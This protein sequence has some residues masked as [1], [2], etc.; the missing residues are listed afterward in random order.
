MTAGAEPSTIG[1]QRIIRVFRYLQGLDQLRNPPKKCLSDHSW[2]LWLKNLPEHPTVLR[3][4]PVAFLSE[5][6]NVPSLTGKQ[7][8]TVG[9]DFILKVSRP[10]P[11]LAPEPPSQ[12]AKWLRSGWDEIDASIEVQPSCLLTRADGSTYE[13]RFEDEESRPLLLEDWRAKRK[14]WERDERPALDAWK[15]FERLYELHGQLEREGERI[16]LVLGDGILSW[17]VAGDEIRYPVILQRLQLHFNPS[18][19]QITLDES[20]YPVELN[21]ALLRTL[22][23][24]DGSLI[25]HLRNELQAKGF[26]PLDGD[27]TS[28]YFRQLVVQ[29]SPR[30]ELVERSHIKTPSSHPVIYRDPVIFLRARTHGF[31]NAIE[32]ILKDIPSRTEL[33]NSLLSIVG[34]GQIESSTGKDS[35]PLLLGEEAFDDTLFCKPAN[36]EQLQIARRLE[37]YGAVLTQG[38]PGTGK[39]YTIANLLGHLLAHGKTVLV[40]SHTSKALR[41]LRNQV[42][43]E[44]QPL[45]VSHLDSD[46][47]SRK[48]MERSVTAISE[49]LTSTNYEQLAHDAQI[50]S[51][52]RREVMA[53]IYDVRRRLLD[54]LTREYEDIQTGEGPYSPS[55]AARTV[56]DGIG[57]HDWIPGPVFM[58][59]AMPLTPEEIRELYLT[60]RTVSAEDER[61]LRGSLPNASDILDPDNFE[62]IVGQWLEL[63]DSQRTF[64]SIIWE[65]TKDGQDPDNLEAKLASITQSVQTVQHAP[66]W[67]LEAMDSG[68]KGGVH[69][70]VWED[71][72]NLILQTCETGARQEDE[73]IRL[74]PKL[75][76]GIELQEQIRNLCEIVDHLRH[77]KKLGWFTLLRHPHWRRLVRSAQIGGSR[78]SLDEHFDVLQNLAT[79]TETRRHLRKMYEH[80]MTSRGAPNISEDDEKPEKI[81]ERA[82]SAIHKACRWYADVWQ[83]QQRTLE[84]L[85]F[86]WLSFLA[87]TSSELADH[88]ELMRLHTAVTRDLPRAFAARINQLR[89]RKVDIQLSEQA[90]QLSQRIT[91]LASTQVL[92]Q[93]HEA[94]LGRNPQSYRTAFQRLVD[95][96]LRLSDL[97]R[98]NELIGRLDQVASAWAD[99]IRKRRPPHHEDKP[100]SDAA[101]AWC[102]RQLRDG[103]DLRAGADMNG[104]QRDIIKLTDEFLRTTTGLVDRLA[105][106]AQVQRTTHK[107]RQALMGW[108]QTIRKIGAGTGKRVPQLRAQARQ[109]MTDC[110]SSVPVWIMPLARALES[111]DPCAP[112]FDVLIIDEASQSDVTALVALYLAHKVIIVGDHEQVTPEAV[113]QDLSHIQSLINEHLT[114]I[115]NRQL[116]D[117]RTSIY[118]LAMH[119]FGGVIPLIEHFRC[120]QHI[121]EFSNKLSYEGRIKPLR[122]ASHVLTRPHVVACQTNGIRSESGVNE[123]EALTIAS[124]LAAAIEQPEYKNN[125]FG[126]ISLVGEDQAGRV[127]AILRQ[128]VTPVE[129]ER[130]RVMCGSAAQFQGDER[131]VTFLSLVDDSGGSRLPLRAS[132]M[133][134]KRFNVAASR[135]RDQM[136]II[137]SLYPAQDLQPDDLRRQL[138]EYAANPERWMPINDDQ[139]RP[140]S[141]LELAVREILEAAH[142]QVVRRWRVGYHVLDMVVHGNGRK[143]AIECEGDRH[144]SAERLQERLNRQV[145]LERLGW[146][147]FRIR[148][149]DFFLDTP[150]T[151]SC[152]F[153]QLHMLKIAPQESRPLEQ[154]A[155]RNLV[156]EVIE[157]AAELRRTW[158]YPNVEVRI[159]T[160]DYGAELRHMT[161]YSTTRK[162]ISSCDSPKVMQHCREMDSISDDEFR[163]VLLECVPFTGEIEHNHLLLSA[164]HRLGYREVPAVLRERFRKAVDAERLAGQLE[165]IS[166]VQKY[167]RLRSST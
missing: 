94:V 79:L 84:E 101:E 48:E 16:E 31:S 152:I 66:E 107:Q 38:P 77:G 153:K 44:L 167:R 158:G 18:I 154:E 159:G 58:G 42:V 131:D 112:P 36:R 33:P 46:A 32:A 39:T 138:I 88:A 109:L 102:W 121:I 80:L 166:G 62:R 8:V 95:L 11:A 51:C 108:L 30:G 99:A 67:E 63:K 91:G 133:F 156:R 20:D 50:T 26:H 35:E 148:A 146:Q 55:D 1:R 122:D 124:L 150:G 89:F 12:L 140:D 13:V 19:P 118:D 68:R 34:I 125:T 145:V 28:D 9:R 98:R 164:A 83:A 111:F 61:E 130:R 116:Y 60:N 53:R 52:E 86:P 143:L 93:L 7:P 72:I 45:C 106:A 110:R 113:G 70:K 139:G 14:Q 65:D 37:L 15:L 17:C 92:A 119:S 41:V 103:L 6:P 96:G 134:R 75:A 100:P 85:G 151:M 74:E 71:L 160:A 40:T 69:G 4:N 82:V 27:D 21:A 2:L 157:R 161:V 10:L 23:G 147:F 24:A 29:L 49:R 78:P 162:V 163:K 47:Q 3:G 141:D 128:H 114:D 5:T 117:G 132:D 43:P 81:C 104:M 87:Q 149:S 22:P 165:M 142:Y 25:S 136:W 73:I 126:V 127:E 105:W 129:L 144:V 90:T 120:I 57:R 155:D 135:A 76:L 54:A 137:H 59:A 115:P 97:R 64:G 123:Q 56:V